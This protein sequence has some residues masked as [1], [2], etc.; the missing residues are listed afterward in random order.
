MVVIG[1]IISPLLKKAIRPE[2]TAGIK[3]RDGKKPN[4]KKNDQ[5]KPGLPVFA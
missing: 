3:D 1:F 5:G 4:K 2:G